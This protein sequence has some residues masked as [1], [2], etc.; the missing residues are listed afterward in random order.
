MGSEEK[1]GRRAMTTAIW[2]SEAFDTI[3]AFLFPRFHT[4]RFLLVEEEMADGLNT[5]RLFEGIGM[6]GVFFWKE[7]R[8][9]TKLAGLAGG[10]RT[11]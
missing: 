10:G 7:N 11:R 5:S 6:F 3:R 8:G 1:A 9:R 2:I 4:L